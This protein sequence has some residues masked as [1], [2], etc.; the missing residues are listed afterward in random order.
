M[1]VQTFFLAEE[2]TRLA[3][4]RHDVRRAAIAYLECTPQSPFPQR[5]TLVG[6][7]LLRRES[8]GGEAPFTLRFD[9]VDEDG[10]PTGLPRRHL[11]QAI[12]PAGPRFYILAGQIEF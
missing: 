4:N 5:F 2:I 9:L 11:L 6:L 8:T 1:E 3:D 7:I 10:R 12:F